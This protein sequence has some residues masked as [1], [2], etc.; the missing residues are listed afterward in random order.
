MGE[1]RDELK[2]RIPDY[3][4][5]STSHTTMPFSEAYLNDV[6]LYNSCLQAPLFLFYHILSSQS[7]NPSHGYPC[8]KYVAK[9]TA[10]KSIAVKYSISRPKSSTPP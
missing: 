5:N 3:N 7:L 9:L 8:S 1:A 10:V 4:L 6:A 2:M